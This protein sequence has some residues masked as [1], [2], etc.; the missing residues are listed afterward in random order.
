MALR[1]RQRH[2]EGLGDLGELERFD[3]PEHE[4]ETCLRVDLVEDGVET[5][6]RFAGVI[7][8]CGRSGTALQLLGGCEAH[9]STHATTAKLRPGDAHCDADEETSQ[10]A[11]LSQPAD[12]TEETQE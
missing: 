2:V 10:R 7:V 1:G 12:L 8:A 5:S 3:V 6:D 4:K 11:R 9:E